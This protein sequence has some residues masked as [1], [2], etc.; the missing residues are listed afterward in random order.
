VTLTTH[1]DSAIELIEHRFHGDR[2]PESLAYLRSHAYFNQ[3][4]AADACLDRFLDYELHPGA[5]G[6]LGGDGKGALGDL[7]QPLDDLVEP[8]RNAVATT[9]CSSYLRMMSLE[10]PVGG[11]WVPE[12][13]AERL[14]NFWISHLRDTATVAFGLPGRFV[15]SVGREGGAGLEAEIKRLGLLPGLLK[16]RGVSDRCVQLSKFGLMLRLGQ[17]TGCSKAE[18]DAAQAGETARTWPF[19]PA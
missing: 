12:R 19:R 5:A 9:I 3:L 15:A 6:T 7:I 10:D 18:F 1:I 11:D 2:G 13:A 16:R 17:T 14:W 8:L 4:P